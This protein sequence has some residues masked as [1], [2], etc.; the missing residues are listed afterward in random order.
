MTARRG[1]KGEGGGARERCANDGGRESRWLPEPVTPDVTLPPLPHRR[2]TEDAPLRNRSSLTVGEGEL[3]EA[4]KRTDESPPPTRNRAR[5]VVPQLSHAVASLPYR[6]HA[7]PSACAHAWGRV[8]RRARC[9]VRRS[10]RRWR[11][12]RGAQRRAMARRRRGDD[13]ATARRRRRRGYGAATARRR[14]GDGVV[15]AR[16]RRGGVLPFA[17]NLTSDNDS[18]GSSILDGR[19]G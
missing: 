1:T 17:K 13:A 2:P 16:R 11:T 9:G 3:R 8:G 7:H 5:G 19:D 10:A 18:H 15:T 4:D 6:L 14:C 12:A